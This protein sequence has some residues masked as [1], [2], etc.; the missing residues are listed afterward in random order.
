MNAETE[1]TVLKERHKAAQ[2][3]ASKLGV[4]VGRV[5][6]EW[7]AAENRQRQ[8]LKDLD[9][10]GFKPGEDLLT[11]LRRVNAAERRES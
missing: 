8:W 3:I 5:F 9:S 2:Q 10:L 6:M 7:R 1:M 4:S 11:F